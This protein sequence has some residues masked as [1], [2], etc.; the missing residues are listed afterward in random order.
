[1]SYSQYPAAYDSFTYRQ[2]V[3]DNVNAIDVNEIQDGVKAVEQTLGI[4]PQGSQNTVAER[5]NTSMDSAGNI[6]TNSTT[7][8]YFLV[9]SGGASTSPYLQLSGLYNKRLTWNN[10]SSRFELN[11]NGYFGGSLTI[12]SN[13]GIAGT[14]S[15]VTSLTM[16]SQLINTLSIGTS[17]FVITSTTKVSNLNVDL[18]DGV[19]VASLTN[20]RLLRYNSAGTQIENATI[21][22]SSGALAGITTLGL[23]GAIAG[24]TTTNTINNI[25]INNGA[26]S[27]ISSLNLSGAIT[28]AT[29]TNTINGLII[30]SGALSGIGSLTMGGKFYLSAVA[31]S[32]QVNVKS[33]TTSTGGTWAAFYGECDDYTAGTTVAMGMRIA[34]DTG[35]LG[36]ERTR[37]D[38]G[39]S[40]VVKQTDSVGA[41]FESLKISYTKAATFAGSVSA[42]SYSVGAT[43]GFNGSRTW[44]DYSQDHK[45]H[46]VTITNGII[47]AWTAS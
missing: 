46:T 32:A 4:N 47:T 31:A 8:Q 30:N 25:I 11:G 14:L 40:F 26:I 24:A 29:S 41:S 36:L 15:G 9:D 2:N 45:T 21:T 38:N 43:P 17:P 28:G 3:T 16:S 6:T 33:I 42:T 13:L 35:S 37:N 12:A 34:G 7:A 18:I 10:S 44:E 20:T 5:F 23:S 27:N 22:E 19:N 1:M 39:L